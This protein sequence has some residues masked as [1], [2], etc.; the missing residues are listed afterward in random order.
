LSTNKTAT[1]TGGGVFVACFLF[2]KLLHVINRFKVIFH[3]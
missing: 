3:L 1:L 2:V